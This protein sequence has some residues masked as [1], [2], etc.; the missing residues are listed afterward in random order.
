MKDILKVAKVQSTQLQLMQATLTEL[1]EKTDK[2]GN[3]LAA[4]EWR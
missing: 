3:K 4:I 2:V 1:L